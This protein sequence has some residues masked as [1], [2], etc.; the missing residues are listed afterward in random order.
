MLAWW[1]VL[2]C[3]GSSQPVD[4]FLINIG[5]PFEDDNNFVLVKHAALLM[6][7][8]MSQVL[9]MP[10]VNLFDDTIAEDLIAQPAGK[11]AVR[12]VGVVTNWPL[13]R[14]RKIIEG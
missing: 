3:N 6:S 14:A 10:N 2:F 11:D 8:L 4:A 13:F 1:A 5:V 12:I 9:V 7:P